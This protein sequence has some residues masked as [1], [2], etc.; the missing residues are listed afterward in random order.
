VAKRQ[1]LAKTDGLGP[2]EVKKIRAALRL[3][4]HQNYT[5]KLVVDRCT[6]AEGYTFCEQ[7]DKRTPKLKIDHIVNCGDVDEGFIKRMFCPSSG[8]QGLCH[9]CHKAKTR[10]ERARA[11]KPARKAR[12]KKIP[13]KYDGGC[14]PWE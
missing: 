1:K 10:E 12:R 7:C 3:V 2:L 4:W 11:K 5:Q 8:L 6:N 9:E 14:F 13:A